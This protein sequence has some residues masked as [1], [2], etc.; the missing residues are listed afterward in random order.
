MTEIIQSVA[1]MREWSRKARREDKSIGFVPT[2]G[3][4]HEGHAAL[5]KTARRE[6]PRLVASIFVNPLQFDRKD[7][8]TRY[9]RTWESDMRMCERF[10]VDAVFAPDEAGLYPSEQLTFVE[11]PVLSAH[12][13]GAHRLGHFQG[14]ATV[15]LKLFNIVQPDRAYFGRKDAQQLA[16]IQRMVTDLNVPITVVPVETV[17]ESDGLAL[18]SRNKHLSPEERLAAPLLSRALR[19]AVE[20]I[21]AGEH[22]SHAIKQSVLPLFSRSSLTRV[23]YFEIVDP[24][25]M[26]PVSKIDGPVLIAGAMWLGSTRLIDNILWSDTNEEIG[27][28]RKL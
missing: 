6:N 2:M 8:L 22:F 28:R 20:L 17:R 19:Q 23:E 24:E 10:G 5:L 26:S 3:A 7:D 15:V 9:P 21:D 25:T 4:L 14:V 11:S 1:A 13:C 16:I 12:L 27:N 18:S